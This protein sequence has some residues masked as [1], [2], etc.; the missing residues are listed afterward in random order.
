MA[1]GDIIYRKAVTK[2]TLTQISAK[3]YAAV[4]F[5]RLT[6]GFTFNRTW[7]RFTGL[8]ALTVI[9]CSHEKV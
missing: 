1:V 9:V 6:K 5:L 4:P 2:Y 3:R 7:G 8:T